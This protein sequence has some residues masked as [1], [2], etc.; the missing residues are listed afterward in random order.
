[1][2][3][4][5]RGAAA[6]ALAI[7]CQACMVHRPPSNDLAALQGHEVRVRSAT[8]F[9]ITRE[10]AGKSTLWSVTSIQ[11]R[12]IRV[13]GDTL[14]L[15]RVAGVATSSEGNRIRPQPEVVTLVRTPAT[16]ITVLR[17]HRG[18]T[19]ALV[20]GVSAVVVG[21]LA[22]AVSQIEFGFPDQ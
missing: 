17:L 10:V 12:V 3:R 9:P 2:R 7:W 22:L 20:L 16:E 18:R 6:L 11:G 14:A 21:L 5:R 15:D 13:V 1:M 19:A 4:S 8:S